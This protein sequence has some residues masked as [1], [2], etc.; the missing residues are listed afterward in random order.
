MNLDVDIASSNRTFDDNLPHQLRLDFNRREMNFTVDNITRIVEFH[1]QY[2]I[3]HLD[4][5][6]TPF[7][8]G[9]RND[10]LEEGFMGIIRSLVSNFQASQI[11]PQPPFVSGHLRRQGGT[12]THFF[13]RSHL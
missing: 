6:G 4:L 9:G 2:G 11:I 7:Y 3:T 10:G 5:D 13:R 12:Y 8:V 1:Y